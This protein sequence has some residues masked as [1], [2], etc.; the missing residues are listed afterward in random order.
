M[1]LTVALTIPDR[2]VEL[3]LAVQTGETLALLGPNGAGKSTVLSSVAGLVRPHDGTIEVDGRVLTDVRG[4]TARQF[5]RPHRRNIALMAQEPLLFPHLSSLENVAFGPRSHGVARHEARK[6]AQAWLDRVHAG[7]HARRLP[8]ELSGGQAQ[9]VALARALAAGPEVILLDEPMAALDAQIAPELRR[10]L[11][12]VL[13]DR[14]AL[15][16]THDLVDALLLADRVVVLENGSIVE[17][18]STLDVLTRPRSAFAAQLADLNMAVGIK[19]GEVIEL[20]DG[21]RIAGQVSG[22]PPA[23]GAPAIVVFRPS[24]VSIFRELPAGSPRNQFRTTITEIHPHGGV[25]RVRAGGLSADIT[26]A[27]A[28]ELAL[29]PGDEVVFT[30]KATEV[31]VYGHRPP[32]SPL[33]CEQ[34]GPPSALRAGL[35]SHRLGS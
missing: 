14:T 21:R 32:S 17:E 33:R 26:L 1:S 29:V 4:G 35:P 30:V 11:Q 10:T 13:A 5:I 2:G 23:D 8:H 27:S 22:E 25:V 9:R 19:R 7:E 31:T 20:P 34:G 18:G 16:V 15:L 12:E 28:A 24:A 3:E 6:T